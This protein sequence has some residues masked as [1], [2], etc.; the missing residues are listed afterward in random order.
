LYSNVMLG[1]LARM[2]AW[3]GML[4][5]WSR[6][7]QDRALDALGRVG[8]LEF[9]GQ[10]ANTLSGGQQQRG[11]I[12]RALTQGAEAILAD[13]PV[14]SLDPVSSRRVMEILQRLNED[15]GLTVIV[16]L[17]QVDHAVRYCRRIVA[18][19]AGRVVYGS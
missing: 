5:A 8:V 18:L 11:A 1:A 2:P 16:T 4:G 3:R 12:A 7:D 6:A 10:R 19:K 9:A 14:A 15:D 17:H 13:E